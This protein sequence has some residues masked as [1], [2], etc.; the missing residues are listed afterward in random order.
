MIIIGLPL[1]TL[2]YLFLLGIDNLASV[3]SNYI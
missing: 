3:A 1:K 2:I